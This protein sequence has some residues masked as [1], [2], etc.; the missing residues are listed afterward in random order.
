VTD[1]LHVD[2]RNVGVNPKINNL[3][4]PFEQSTYD[5][6]YILDSTISM[7][8]SSLGRAVDAFLGTTS[9]STTSSFDRND[10]ESTPLIADEIRSPP[11]KGDV[12][13]VHHVP[14]AV[15][16]QR[17]WGSLVE[18][19]FLNTTHAKMYLAIVS[20][21]KLLISSH[22]QCRIAKR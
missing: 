12:G 11:Q 14:Y 20:S 17:T 21:F 4:A 16:Y 6:L 9:S 7:H 10:L 2:N 5:L 13:L 15:V 19:A 1:I 22:W 3:I 8:P 18:Q